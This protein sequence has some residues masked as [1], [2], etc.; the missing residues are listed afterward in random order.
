MKPF[1]LLLLIAISLNNNLQAQVKKSFSDNSLALT[2]TPFEK[3][4]GQQ[5][6]TYLQAI[7][8]YEMLA[9]KSTTAKLMCMGQTDAGQ[10]L[11]LFLM[12]KDHD[13]NPQKWHEK[14]KVV[15]LINNGIHAGEPDGI[16]ACMMMARDLLT[17]NSIPDNVAIGI[18]P[19]YNIGGC[20]NRSSTS[21]ANQN[22]PEDYGF[23][24][25]SQ[26]LDLNRDFTKCDSKEAK[27]FSQIFQLLNPDIFIDNHVSDGA[28][29]QHT[30]TLLTTQYDKLGKIQGEW[31]RDHFE[32]L[33]YASM[34]KKGWDL[35]PYVDFEYTDTHKGMTMFY[36]PPRY[37]SGYAALFHS[38]SFVPE[39]HMLKPFSQRVKS[40]YD[41]M[42][43]MIN[44]SSIN[45]QAIIAKRKE[46]MDYCAHQTW[47]PLKWAPDTT[48]KN[49]MIFKGYEKDSAVSE[50]TGLQKYYFN[51][52]KPFVQS[53]PFYCY[54]KAIDSVKV[55][56][57]YIIQAG[58]SEVIERMKTN[59]VN[60][61]PLK[62]DTTIK[63]TVT[64]IQSYKSYPTAYEKHHKNYEVKTREVTD[65][66]RFLA[67]DF[68]ISSRQ[69]TRRY[70]AEMLEPRG[71]DSFFAW[72]FFDAILQQKEGYS[73]Y[74]WEDIAAKILKENPLLQKE[75]E[76]K[77]Q[78]EP[79]FA[80][81]SHQILDFIYKHSA[82]YE[83][84]HMRLPVYKVE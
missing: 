17:H 74:R 52:Q 47:L 31:L 79:A 13:F 65:S 34:A 21:R 71:D 49:Q 78:N 75:L 30:M 70:L 19:V 54:F 28:D 73:D 35:V 32:P 61:M 37:G 80:S 41:L 66:I 46:E 23:R 38:F 12:S 9:Q 83:K 68:L 82:Y 58:W 42:F 29:Y 27:S 15:L 63:V 48:K 26:L 43:S 25:N 50:A 16:D 14:G 64:Y 69:P 40:T 81:D 20:L 10:P 5:S 36:E 53:I 22:G 18:I 33:I 67:G 62:N 57:N 56:E 84:S 44:E 72:N 8:W 77:K 6:A 60:M 11:H 59:G 51:H 45:S 1:L 24:G 55:P 7:E 76:E 4:G 39:T 2:Q 3:S